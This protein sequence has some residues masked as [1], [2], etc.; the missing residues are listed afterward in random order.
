WSSVRRVEIVY[1]WETALLY[2]DGAFT[3]VL[4]PGRHV[5]FDV[6]RSIYLVRVPAAPRHLRLG[7][8]EVVSSD[9]FAFR[10][11]LALTY[12]ILDA[13]AVHEEQATPNQ[14]GV[15]DPPGL[16]DRVAT[17]AMAAVGAVPLDAVT[18]APGTLADAI[19]QSL[20]LTHLGLDE[21]M[22][23]RVELPPETRRMLSEVERAR[24]DGLAALERARGEQAALR[25]L[26]NAARLVRDNPELAQL[27]LLQ[28]IDQARRPATIILGQPGM[29]VGVAPS[30]A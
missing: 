8:T 2:R 5:F 4:K 29:P 17:A 24:R 19:R 11:H 23:V 22:V 21:V 3:R 30:P 12:R 18:S 26:A 28:T 10:L 16:Q 14:F 7:A 1:P 6:R 9:G 13:R 20:T 27:R 15:G 25:S